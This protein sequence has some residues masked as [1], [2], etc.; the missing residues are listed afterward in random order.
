MEPILFA[1]DGV[2]GTLLLLPPASIP[3]AGF[4][5]P[6]FGTGGVVTPCEVEGQVLAFAVFALVRSSTG[7]ISAIL[8]FN[9]IVDS[10]GRLYDIKCRT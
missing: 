3:P 1:D 6:P 5:P 7:F 2:G 4:T 8:D 10:K 9:Y